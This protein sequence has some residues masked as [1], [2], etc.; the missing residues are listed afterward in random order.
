[1]RIL[2]FG[3]QI[4]TFGEIYDFPSANGYWTEIKGIDEYKWEYFKNL[5]LPRKK[6]L[7]EKLMKIK[8]KN[9]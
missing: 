6:I 1:M 3:I 5:F 9:V 4:L 2:D 8:A 7:E